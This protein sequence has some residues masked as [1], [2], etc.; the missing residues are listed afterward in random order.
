MIR[1]FT[2][3]TVF[4][5]SRGRISIFKDRFVKFVQNLTH[6]ARLAHESNSASSGFHGFANHGEASFWSAHSEV[7][8]RTPNED[9]IWL[10]DKVSGLGNAMIN[11]IDG[12]DIFWLDNTLVP[13]DFLRYGIAEKNTVVKETAKPE[14]KVFQNTPLKTKKD[15]SF[16]CFESS[17]SFSSPADSVFLPFSGVSLSGD[18]A[19]ESFEPIFADTREWTDTVFKSPGCYKEEYEYAADDLDAAFSDDDLFAQEPRATPSEKDAYNYDEFQ[20]T[21]LSVLS[22]DAVKENSSIVWK[23]KK[24]FGGCEDVDWH[25]KLR[26][27]EDLDDGAG[28]SAKINLEHSE[29][30]D[31][32]DTADSE[33]DAIRS[34]TEKIT[35]SNCEEAAMR[36]SRKQKRKRSR[37]KKN[38]RKQRRHRR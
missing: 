27:D 23:E 33:V 20:D 38:M 21:R 12:E 14:K 19:H 3:C 18:R 7:P 11:Q 25:P 29:E 1:T 31:V 36:S 9:E 8:E 4:Y 16:R 22:Y 32:V 34:A 35:S 10:A 2:H 5:P 26:D 28:A 37:L 13:E 15:E 17:E 6:A 30:S 24:T